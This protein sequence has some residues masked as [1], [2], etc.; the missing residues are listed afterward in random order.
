MDITQDIMV[1]MVTHP[2]IIVQ[3]DITMTIIMDTVVQ[4]LV[5]LPI[6]TALSEPVPAE[7]V[8]P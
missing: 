1:V 2:I 5:I 4:E 3:I 7:K 8:V 6:H